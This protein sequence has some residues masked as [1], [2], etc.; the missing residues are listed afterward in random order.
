MEVRWGW[1]SETLLLN[2]GNVW[3][4]QGWMEDYFFLFYQKMQ[5]CISKSTLKS[6]SLPDLLFFR[7]I[8]KKW[9]NN[10]D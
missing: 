5:I 10:F 6:L 9:F 8:I 2:P 4:S 7:K 1:T 3:S